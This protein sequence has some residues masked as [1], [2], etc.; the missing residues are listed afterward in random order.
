MV[1]LRVAR[2]HI[3]VLRPLQWTKN[4][5]VFAALLFARQSREPGQLGKAA[6]VFAAFCLVSSALYVFNDMRDRKAD[7]LHPRKRL[8]PI[9][10]GAVRLETASVLAPVLAVLGFLAARNAA[11]AALACLTGYL[12]LGV[13]YS[14]FLKRIVIVDVLAIAAGFIL[15]AAAGAYAIDVAISQWL[16]ICTLL[17]ALFLALAKRR[18]ELVEFA[19]PL[20]QRSVLGEYTPA[21]LDQMIAV[22]T[23]G[24]L[25]A[26]ILYAFSE[27]TNAKFPS[28]LMP[29]TIPF[30]L[31]GIFRYLYLIYQRAEGGEP[32]RLL[33]RD[34]PLLVNIVLYVLAVAAIVGA[35]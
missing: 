22:V 11:P 16:L 32:E 2:D 15:R 34:T 18:H 5:L 17:L 12:A 30:V 25:M 33:V 6:V 8:R 35:R 14:L 10:S 1:L 13:F 24:T 26:Y 20:A 3:A 19:K 9:P 21:L 31:Y 4:L 27:Q 23:S 29:L 7:R 28:H